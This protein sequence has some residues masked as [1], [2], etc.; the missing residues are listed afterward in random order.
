MDSLND[1][2]EACKECIVRSCCVRNVDIGCE[3]LAKFYI[4][5]IEKVWEKEKLKC[6]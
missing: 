4:K 5:K 2:P 1:S 6:V 3:E